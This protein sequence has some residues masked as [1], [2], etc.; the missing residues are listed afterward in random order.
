MGCTVLIL[1]LM[2]SGRITEIRAL[3][4]NPKRQ[5]KNQNGMKNFHGE[6]S[7]TVGY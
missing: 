4:Q 5:Y 6:V 1:V 7:S 2:D 3:S